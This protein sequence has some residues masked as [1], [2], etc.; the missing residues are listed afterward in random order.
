MQATH[1]ERVLDLARRP[2]GGTVVL[3]G[4]LG[5]WRDGD[6]L[7]RGPRRPPAVTFHLAIAPGGEVEHPDGCWRLVLDRPEPAPSGEPPRAGGLGDAVFDADAL[8][9][10]L[11]VRS[12]RLGDRV[13]VPGLGTRKLQDV[14]V[15]AKVP[16]AARDAVPLLEAAG[17]IV[18]VAGVARASGARI[19]PATRRIVRGR[20]E[21]PGG[22]R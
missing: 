8:P 14:L 2:A 5:V 11:V 20:L 3:P 18:W 1:V 16:R 22:R 21:A 9:A 4:G 13:H 15:D 12:R 17:A 6:R 7:L 19:G 10:E